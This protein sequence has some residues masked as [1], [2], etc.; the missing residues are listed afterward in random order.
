VEGGR[1]RGGG[2]GAGGG[3]RLAGDYTGCFC[4]GVEPGAIQAEEERFE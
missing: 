2:L 1:G 3:V 4:A